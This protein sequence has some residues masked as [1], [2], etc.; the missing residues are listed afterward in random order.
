M[1]PIT[2][3]ESRLDE[4]LDS[5]FNPLQITS[6]FS[7]NDFYGEWKDVQGEIKSSLLTLGYR[8]WSDDGEDYTMADDWGLSR[9]HDVEIHSESMWSDLRVLPV[10]Q[11]VLGGLNQDYQVVVHHDLFLRGEIAMC[12]F[13]VQKNTI[14]SQTDDPS[15]LKRLGLES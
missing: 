3:S 5:A 6:G 14:F 12:H 8:S 11:Q 9:S 7:E 10:I 13:I 2:I 4:I 15:L 1:K